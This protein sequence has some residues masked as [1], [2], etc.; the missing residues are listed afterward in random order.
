MKPFE[1]SLID[2][3]GS[4]ERIPAPLPSNGATAIDGR[5]AR[6]TGYYA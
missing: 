5:P 1:F 3:S 4:G 2:A 6:S